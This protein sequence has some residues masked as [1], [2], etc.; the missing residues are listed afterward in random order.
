MVDRRQYGLLSGVVAPVVSFVSILLATLV[1]PAFSWT[2]KALSNLG[3]H[4]DGETLVYALETGQAEFFLFNGGLVI[5]ATVGLGFLWVLYDDA[6][7]GLELIGS[8]LFGLGLLAL[9]GVGVVHLGHDHHTLVSIAYFVL[10]GFSLL[11]YGAGRTLAG[12][13][14]FGL[15]TVGVG[16]AFAL[17]W[18]LWSTMVPASVASGV[19]I[20][21]FVSSMLFAGWAFGTASAL[22]WGDRLSRRLREHLDDPD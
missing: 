17:T 18:I 1:D 11:F 4:P 3:E 7:T 21:E 9:A 16:L 8:G 12:E 20:P 22:L 15:L 14:R 5:T 2:D 10:T 13:R 6:E 19:A